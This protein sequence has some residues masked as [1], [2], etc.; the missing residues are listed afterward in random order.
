VAQL[1]KEKN[2]QIEMLRLKNEEELNRMRR[3]Y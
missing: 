2:Y 1:Q 3:D